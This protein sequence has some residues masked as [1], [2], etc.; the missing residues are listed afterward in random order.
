MRRV[1]W[2]LTAMKWP[3]AGII[4]SHLE[5]EISVT[6]NDLDIAALRVVRVNNGTAVPGTNADIEDEHVVLLVTI[7]KSNLRYSVQENTDPMQVDRMSQEEG[8][9]NNDP[10]R[11]VRPEI[12]NIPFRIIWV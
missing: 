4:R 7:S 6:W 12:V 5:D 9:F 10:D 3:D 2:L 1:E 8:V 11:R